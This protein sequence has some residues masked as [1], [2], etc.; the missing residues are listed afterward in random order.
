MGICTKELIELV[1]APTLRELEPEFTDTQVTGAANLLLATAAAES[2]LSF[3]LHEES[4]GYGIYDISKLEHLSVWDDFLAFNEDLASLVRGFASQHHFLADPNMELATNLNYA[5]A[6][7]W[8]LYKKAEINPEELLQNLNAYKM[9]DLWYRYFPGVK[10][11]QS[12]GS[13]VNTYFNCS[14]NRGKFAA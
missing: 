9:A 1:I 13:F 14:L 6:I 12:K 4:K 2:G 5:T 3:H 8:C 10:D 7:A 11:D